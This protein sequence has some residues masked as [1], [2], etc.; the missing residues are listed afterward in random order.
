MR[1]TPAIRGA[2]VESVFRDGVRAL[3]H[4]LEGSC[5]ADHLGELAAFFRALGEF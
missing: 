4:F 1:N 2:S 3:V 5:K